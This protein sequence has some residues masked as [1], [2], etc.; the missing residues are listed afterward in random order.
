MHY[1]KTTYLCHMLNLSIQGCMIYKIHSVYS[2]CFLHNFGGIDNHTYF[3]IILSDTIDIFQL[4]S[5]TSGNW[6]DMECHISLH[7]KEVY[8]ISR[9]HFAYD[10]FHNLVSMIAHILIHRIQ[11]CRKNTFPFACDMTYLHSSWDTLV[12][13]YSQR[14][15]DYKKS[16]FHFACGID[17][18]YSV[19][20][21]TNYTCFKKSHFC[22]QSMFPSACHR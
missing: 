12:H 20:G 8:K 4:V 13:I 11:A 10:K 2:I 1:F 22:M 5:R 21:M 6:L 3:H 14:T 18:R 15:Q 17:V 7:K 16:K 9:C 19:M